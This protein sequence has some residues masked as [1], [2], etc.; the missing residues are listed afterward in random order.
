MKRLNWGC[1]PTARFGWDNTDLD[2][3]PGLQFT[4]D[5]LKGLPVSDETYDYIV[6]IHVL[7]ELAYENQD[8]A[9]TELRRTLKPGGILRLGLPDMDRAIKAYLERDVDYFLIGDDVIRD[10]AGKLIVQLTWYGRS[11]CLFTATM[12]RELLERNGYVDVTVYEFR[13]SNSGLPGITDL[14]DRPLESFFIEGTKAK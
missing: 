14:D 4:A 1:G 6:G 2:P 11:R 3:W 12:M 13:Q 8:R 5:I 10:L 7:P 9:L